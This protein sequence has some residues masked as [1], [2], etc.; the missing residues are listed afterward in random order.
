M[1]LFER[2][3]YMILESL[4]TSLMLWGTVCKPGFWII[5]AV[6]YKVVYTGVQTSQLVRIQQNTIL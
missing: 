3:Y 2:A 6:S 1:L 5:T 4:K